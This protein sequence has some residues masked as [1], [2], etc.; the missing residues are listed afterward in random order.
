MSKFECDNTPLLNLLQKGIEKIKPLAKHNPTKQK[1]L[2]TLIKAVDIYKKDCALCK[3]QAYNDIKC[4]KAALDKLFRKLPFIHKSIYP[5]QNY[6][7]DYGNYIDNNYSAMAT[8]SSKSGNAVFKNLGI[9]FKLFKAYMFSANPSNKSVAGG[10]DKYSDYPVYGCLGNNKRICDVWNK[11]KNSDKESIPY[12]D[13]FFNKKTRGKY[14]SSY[15]VKVGS[16]PR[17]DITDR[18]KC[19][20][21]DYKWID[22]PLD[23][24]L[25]KNANQP[26]PGSCH[27]P[28]YAFINNKPGFPIFRGYLPSLANDFLS[29]TPDKMYRAFNGKSISGYLDVQN[30][31]QVKKT[32]NGY[33]LVEGFNTI[34]EQNLM[35]R[36]IIT[37][38][39]IVLF[40]TLLV[41]IYFSG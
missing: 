2:N 19:A 24:I 23:S 5:W 28:R 4:Q 7:W 9:F 36:K 16:C 34:E 41:A 6:E 17:P 21:L 32:P 30:C 40:I 38:T 11:V 8:G 13:K 10:K 14:S 18:N 3:G 12:D 26:P 31:P 27:Q 22:N 1:E 20:E 25:K 39:S 33:K 29:M 37:I 35:F 15:F